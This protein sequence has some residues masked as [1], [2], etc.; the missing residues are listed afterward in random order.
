MER[1]TR[2]NSAVCLID[3]QVGLFSGVRDISINE[4]KHNV[5]C[6]AKAAQIFGIPIIVAT[7]AKDIFWGPTFPELIAALD[8]Q[9]YYSIDRMTVN[10]WDDANFV[11][12]V[13]NTG[14][15]HLIFAGISLQVC[16]ALPAYSSLAEGYMAYIAV[17]ASGTFSEKQRQVGIARIQQAGVIPIDY[18]S[19]MA[20]ILA[21]NADPLA[22]KVYTAIDMDFATLMDQIV[23]SITT[24]LTQK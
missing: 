12:M 18:A 13:K 9:K 7:T 23:E 10:A 5:V 11:K 22:A 2:D 8:K 16:A 20:E 21:T 24:N 3:H 17:D 14:R 19:I 1:I 4:L 6:L 15:K